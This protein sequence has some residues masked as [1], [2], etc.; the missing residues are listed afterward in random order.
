MS[1]EKLSSEAAD[2][3]SRLRSHDNVRDRLLK[4]TFKIGLGTGRSALQAIKLENRRDREVKRHA[5][6]LA[7]Y[8][9]VSAAFYAENHAEL[10][11]LAR[12]EM[13]A[14]G[15]HF[16]FADRR[17]EVAYRYG[18]DVAEVYDRSPLDALGHMAVRI[19]EKYS[20]LVEEALAA[21]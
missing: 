13:E 17:E 14:D 3:Y 18:E 7:H 6:A 4:Q 21:A 11:E 9:S 8:N 10:Y 5:E 2:Q 19:G 1:K 15:V 12:E 16:N 20:H